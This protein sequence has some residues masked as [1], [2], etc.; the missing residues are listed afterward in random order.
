[1]TH[2]KPKQIKAIIDL[3]FGSTGKGLLAGYIANRFK[4]DTLITA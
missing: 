4:P 1:M 2:P 3:Q